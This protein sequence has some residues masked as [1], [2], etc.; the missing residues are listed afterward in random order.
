MEHVLWPRVTS[1]VPHLHAGDW[2]TENCR[3]KL[4]SAGG[5]VR[6]PHTIP[7]PPVNGLAGTVSEE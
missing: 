1:S 5:G 7:A 3:N 2:L 6:L 4:E